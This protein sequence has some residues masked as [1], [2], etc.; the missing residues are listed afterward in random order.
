[1]TEPAPIPDA[2]TEVA[3]AV[4][5]LMPGLRRRAL[6]ASTAITLAVTGLLL[7]RLLRKHES[8]P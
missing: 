8:Q 6:L 4:R 7:C 2:T 1:M 3:L 5:A